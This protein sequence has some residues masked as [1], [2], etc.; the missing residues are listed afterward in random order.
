MCQY[1]INE[2]THLVAAW[3]ASRAASVQ[4]CRFNVKQ[5]RVLL[6]TVGLNLDF[7][8]LQNLP[9]PDAIDEKHKQWR[10]AIIALAKTTLAKP[11]SHGVA[12][13]LINCYLKM[14]FVCGGCSDHKNVVSLHPPI[15]RILLKTL[16][17]K[18]I[19]NH[20]REWKKLHDVGW[21][22]F[23]SDQYEEV[24][25]LVRLTQ[26]DAPLWMIEEFWPGNQ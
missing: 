19:G 12:A 7:C 22:N 13:K 9:S 14:R 5:G 26:Q 20:K 21:S 2:H 4:K 17:I 25:N 11:M 23:N 10:E 3:A 16:A 15:D 8:N 24:I 18:N 6:E 1:T